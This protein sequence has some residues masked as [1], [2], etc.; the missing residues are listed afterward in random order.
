MFVAL[1]VDTLF[2]HSTVW[3][4]GNARGAAAFDALEINKTS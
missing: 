3:R 1:V 2:Q 4:Q